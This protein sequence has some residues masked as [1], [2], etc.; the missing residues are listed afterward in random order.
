MTSRIAVG[1][2]MMR[3]LVFLL[4]SGNRFAAA[5]NRGQAPAREAA[6]GVVLRE[7]S[8]LADGWS[9]FGRIWSMEETGESCGGRS[10]AIERDAAR[11]AGRS[12]WAENTGRDGLSP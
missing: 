5:A 9:G 6:Y 8:R 1:K 3:E 11:S 7:R 12:N 4:S 10:S 2:K